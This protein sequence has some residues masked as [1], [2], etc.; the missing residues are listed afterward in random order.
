M[1]GQCNAIQRSVAAVLLDMRTVEDGVVTVADAGRG[2]RT[3]CWLRRLP[4]RRIRYCVS[5]CHM[6]FQVKRCWRSCCPS[7]TAQT[8]PR[9]RLGVRDLAPQDMHG[10]LVLL[11]GARTTVTRTRGKTR[12]QT[13]H[14]YWICHRSWRHCSII[15]GVG[16]PRGK[17]TWPHLKTQNFPRKY[18]DENNIMIHNSGFLKHIRLK[19]ILITRQFHYVW[20][21]I[22]RILP[23]AVY[24]WR[25][26]G[27]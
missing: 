19:Y 1:S 25:L 15:R 24:L 22:E 7:S 20:I 14:S 21:S 17:T 9:E 23:G 2:T 18:N 8:V 5:L 11:H 10:I 3:R 13:A 12:Q 27:K 4:W 6:K 16:A 26:L